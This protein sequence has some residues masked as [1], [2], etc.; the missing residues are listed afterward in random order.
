MLIVLFE[1]ELSLLKL[2]FQLL[3]AFFVALRI[4]L[5]SAFLLAKVVLGELKFL[6]F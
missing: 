3:N 2:L 1:Q 5:N 6:F 4:T